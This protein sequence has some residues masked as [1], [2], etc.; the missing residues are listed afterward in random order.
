MTHDYRRPPRQRVDDSPV[1]HLR[2][3][4]AALHERG[5][6]DPVGWLGGDAQL[7]ARQLR[8]LSSCVA[9]R[10][11]RLIVKDSVDTLV[12]AVDILRRAAWRDEDRVA[13]ADTSDGRVYLTAGDLRALLEILRARMAS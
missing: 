5:D 8:Q 6:D 2:A 12:D 10:E 3:V 9:G 1:G 13:V 11:H 7:R 4:V